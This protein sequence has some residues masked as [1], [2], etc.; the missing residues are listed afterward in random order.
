MVLSYIMTKHV[1]SKE[2]G[3][4][5]NTLLIDFESILEFDVKYRGK[6]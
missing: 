5:E 6:A 1:T 3:I 2:E 4:E